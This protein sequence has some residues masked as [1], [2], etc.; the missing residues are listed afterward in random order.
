MLDL[1]LD[2]DLAAVFLIVGSINGD[3]EGGRHHAAQP[4]CSIIG[5]S[6]A[7]AHVSHPLRG[8][9]HD[10]AS[11]SVGSAQSSHVLTLEEAVHRPSPSRIASVLGLRRRG[12]LRLRLRGLTP[13][14]STP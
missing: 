5:S 11:V 3:D 14:S 2:E 8:G 7:G 4:T 1:A 13:S 12:L 6:D 9:R 10:P